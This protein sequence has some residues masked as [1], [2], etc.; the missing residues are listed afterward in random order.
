[1]H[2]IAK[3]GLA[4]NRIVVRKPVTDQCVTVEVLKVAQGVTQFRRL[5]MPL[6]WHLQCAIIGVPRCVQVLLVGQ[7]NTV[8]KIQEVT[9]RRELEDSASADLCKSSKSDEELG[10]SNLSSCRS[11]G[12]RPRKSKKKHTI[13]GVRQG[14]DGQRIKGKKY[15]GPLPDYSE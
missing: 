8:M 13:K 1:M 3:N 9:A 4:V 5:Q 2:I 15:G 14:I 6:Q 10:A 7:I 12:L 11:Q